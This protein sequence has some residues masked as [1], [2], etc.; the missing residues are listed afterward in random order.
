M[1]SQACCQTKKTV[2]ALKGASLSVRE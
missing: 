2:A 1:I